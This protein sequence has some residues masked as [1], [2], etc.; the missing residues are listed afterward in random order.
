MSLIETFRNLV[1]K[2]IRYN[3]I[4]NPSDQELIDFFNE[5]YQPP[6]NIVTAGSSTA[7]YLYWNVATSMYEPIT[8]ETLKSHLN[9]PANGSETLLYL[10]WDIGTSKYSPIDLDTL[11]SD[12][13]FSNGLTLNDTLLWSTNQGK[14]LPQTLA[15]LR[16]ALFNLV[17]FDMMFFVNSSESQTQDYVMNP[18]QNQYLY[19]SSG[20]ELVSA[21]INIDGTVSN[22]VISNQDKIIESGESLKVRFSVGQSGIY[23]YI[24]RKR[25]LV[26]DVIYEGTISAATSFTE[27]NMSLK[28]KLNFSGQFGSV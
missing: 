6:G 10:K 22:I 12:L 25:G 24:D 1:F 5:V 11:K 19:L 9:L 8:L 14:F 4:F 27:M 28:Y 15:Y 2:K 13:G 18:C 23:M 7:K 3:T 21:N 20:I 16:N 26:E 17:T